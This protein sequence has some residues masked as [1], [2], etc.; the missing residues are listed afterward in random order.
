[1]W[2]R[3]PHVPAAGHDPLVRREIGS[4]HRPAGVELV[5]ADAD[6]RAKAVFPAVGEAGAGVDDHAGR[7]DAGHKLLNRRGVGR[8]DRIGVMA[9]VAVDVIDRGIGISRREQKKIF[10]KFYRID[11]GLDG[12]P[13]GCGLGLAIVDHTMRGHGGFVRVDS[14]P[15]RGS[16][17]SLHFPIATGVAAADGDRDDAHSGDRGRTADVARSA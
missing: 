7:I 17:F 6:L 14:E 1:M 16:T 10:R 13:Q 11:S 15:D 12:G 9:A 8:E 2:L 4:A 5:G 3:L